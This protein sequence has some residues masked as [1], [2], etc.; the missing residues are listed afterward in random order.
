MVSVRGT[1]ISGVFRAPVA[2][3]LVLSL[4]LGSSPRCACDETTVPPDR[5]WVHS[6]PLRVT[7]SCPARWPQGHAIGPGHGVTASRSRRDPSASDLDG[8]NGGRTLNGAGS[9]V[10]TFRLWVPL[11]R[12]REPQAGRLPTGVGVL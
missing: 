1:W 4:G 7:A 11:P 6:N 3:G 9:T 12:C 2:P 5:G 8:S 10:S